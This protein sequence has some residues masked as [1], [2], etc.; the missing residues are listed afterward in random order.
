M[1]SIVTA[2]RWHGA[3]NNQCIRERFSATC[4][5]VG[6]AC[7]TARR[8]IQAGVSS[9]DAASL[10]GALMRCA[11][12]T[13][14]MSSMPTA[15]TLAM[16]CER[17]SV[18]ARICKPS[19]TREC[20]TTTYLARAKLITRNEGL[21]FHQ[22]HAHRQRGHQ[23]GSQAKVPVERHQHGLPAATRKAQRG[24]R[25][26]RRASDATMRYRRGL[27]RP[28][29]CVIQVSVAT[30]SKLQEEGNHGGHAHPAVHG[31]PVAP[32]R[33]A[34]EMSAPERQVAAANTCLGTT[35]RML[36]SRWKDSRGTGT[37][38]SRQP[39]PAGRRCHAVPRAAICVPGAGRRAHA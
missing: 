27:Q 19:S 20:V 2:A 26:S 16:V 21:L 9:D 15:I 13:K 7:C 37:Q 1:R 33:C 25:P 18:G 23:P 35:V 5:A 14:L 8:R 12:A 22:P 28:R 36:R 24:G 3:A 17:V 10:M 4:T 32:T 34:G 11:P 38:R 39:A 30:S 29:L 6:M 31:V